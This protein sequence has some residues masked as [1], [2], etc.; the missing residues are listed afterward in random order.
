MRT[1][2][3]TRSLGAASLWWRSFVGWFDSEAIAAAIAAA[4]PR[5]IDYPR[6]LPFVGLHL[7]CLAVIWVGVSAVAVGI[8]AA[9]Y[10]LRLF[11]VTG[12]YHRYFSHRAFRTSRIA[13]FI[14]AA[15]GASATQRGP[16]WWAS[17]HR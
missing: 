12:F 3:A 5:Q 10:A 16:L 9:L 2:I 13:Q 11:A 7:A 1:P 6:L 4:P 14:F 17:H 15:L 8:A